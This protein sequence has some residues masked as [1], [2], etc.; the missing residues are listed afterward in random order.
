MKA[1]FGAVVVGGSGKLGG[2][3]FAT[4]RAG[5]YVRTKVTPMNTRTTAQVAVRTRLA[6]IASAW[7]GLGAAA[8][9]AWNNAVSDF[10]STNVFG[11]VVNPTG[12]NLYQ[13]LNN[14]LSNVG[15]TPLT[16]PPL[17]VSVSTFTSASIV[18]DDSAH[19]LIATVAPATLPASEY[20]IVRAAAPVS[21][22]KSFVKSE[23]RQIAVL[24][25]VTAGSF[26]LSA[27]YTAKFGTIGGV[28]KGI[29][30]EFVHVNRTTGQASQPQKI[31]TLIVA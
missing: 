11:D 16:T 7:R 23:F 13:K 6:T 1:K 10:K 18:A 5:A 15:G 29:F 17:P 14:N 28:G 27:A 30:V 19:T 21:G 4:N 25:S 3:V 24:T 31:S 12:F 2:H 20:L 22:G 8:I 9:A 26:D